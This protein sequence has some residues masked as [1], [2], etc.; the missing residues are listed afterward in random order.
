MYLLAFDIKELCLYCIASAVFSISMLVLTVIGR[1]W[2]DIGQIFFTGAIVGVVT[3]IG[4]LAIFSTPQDLI[5][6]EEPKTEPVAPYGWEITM[7]SG[8]AETALAKHLTQTGAKMYGAYWCP[9]CYEQK[10]LFGK[11]A[12]KDITYIECASDGKGKNPQ[13]DLCRQKGV[14]SF[15]TWEIKG[16]LDPGVKV[17]SKLAGASDYQGDS[18]FKYRLP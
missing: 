8:A 15:P 11:E 10:Q 4:T 7:T 13:P 12:S 18:S 6:I 1:N 5:A 9:H 16:K 3:L 2:E 14:Q 17:L